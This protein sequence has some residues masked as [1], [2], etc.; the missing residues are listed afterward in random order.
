MMFKGFFIFF[1]IAETPELN[2]PMY[3]G[4]THPKKQTNAESPH[5]RTYGIT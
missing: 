4:V 3:D 1:Y 5:S 2:H